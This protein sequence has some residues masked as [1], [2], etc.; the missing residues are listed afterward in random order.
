[1]NISDISKTKTQNVF[2]VKSPFIKATSDV[3]NSKFSVVLFDF[4]FHYDI[5]F[6]DHEV[7]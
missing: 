6:D 4:K 3:I 5:K 7:I 2:L 1:M